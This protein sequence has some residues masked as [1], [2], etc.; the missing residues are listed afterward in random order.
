MHLPPSC[1][2]N[3]SGHLALILGS[4]AGRVKQL[5]LSSGNK[6]KGREIRALSGVAELYYQT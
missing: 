1:I 4:R 6:K 3:Y 5:L 2:S